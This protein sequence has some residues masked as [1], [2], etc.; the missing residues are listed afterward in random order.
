MKDKYIEI[1]ELDKLNVG[2]SFSTHLAKLVE[3]NG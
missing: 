1:A 3:E 2:G